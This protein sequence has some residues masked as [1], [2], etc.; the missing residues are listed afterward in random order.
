MGYRMDST[1]M[2]IMFMHNDG[3]AKSI[4]YDHYPIDIVVGLYMQD[5]ID[6]EVADNPPVTFIE[7]C[8]SEGYVPYV[9]S[10]IQF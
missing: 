9:T 8:N 3:K 7:W 10:T 1:L 2:H 5:M 4:P 6:N